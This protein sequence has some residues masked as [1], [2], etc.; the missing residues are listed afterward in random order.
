M[1]HKLDPDVSAKAAKIIYLSGMDHECLDCVISQL[2]NTIFRILIDAL[3]LSDSQI[4]E[5]F[6]TLKKEVKQ[7][8]I[9]DSVQ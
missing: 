6:D 9:A 8:R 5:Y 1:S 2:S 3:E 7:Y 4:D